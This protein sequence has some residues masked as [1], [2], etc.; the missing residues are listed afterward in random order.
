MVRREK[1]ASRVAQTETVVKQEEDNIP[2]DLQGGDE[3][4][5]KELALIK[6]EEEIA[7]ELDLIQQKVEARRVLR[8]M[9]ND[10]LK[11]KKE[12]DKDFLDPLRATDI[13]QTI[14]PFTITVADEDD[15]DINYTVTRAHL[16]TLCGGS[17]QATFPTLAPKKR[18]KL[19]EMGF[20]SDQFQCITNDYNPYMP[21][22]PGRGGLFFRSR[23]L[24]DDLS[25]DHQW[26]GGRCRVIV[27]ITSGRWL[28]LGH[29]E[30]EFSSTLTIDE[31]RGLPEKAKKTWVQGMLSKD[32]GRNHRIRIQLRNRPTNTNREVNLAEYTIKLNDT[33]NKYL[34]VVTA[35]QVADALDRGEE[36]IVVWKMACVAYEKEFQRYIV[37]KA[38]TSEEEEEEEE[39][40]KKR[41]A[42]NSD[43]SPPPKR[44]RP[45]TRFSARLEK[46]PRHLDRRNHP[47]SRD[48][49]FLVHALGRVLVR[50][51]F[52]D[53]G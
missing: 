14:A 18:A 51:V 15:L 20:A 31:W 21:S 25:P 19:V 34:G 32:W 48:N 53:L 27:R 22:I 36:A 10:E 13:I 5:K 42:L 2:L 44:P 3:D 24:N 26:G 11:I 1:N 17:P 45:K 46:R 47:R 49:T 7:Q 28:Y 6:K 52:L 43:A 29:Y 12:I 39:T 30:M 16:S 37:K 23:R 8:E 4:K 33:N 38:E 41:K 50:P 40:T 9:R 35:E